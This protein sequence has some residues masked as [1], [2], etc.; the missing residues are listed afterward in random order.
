M[1]KTLAAA[2][3]AAT[4]SAAV[5]AQ[6]PD[7]TPQR[8]DITLSN[9]SFDPGHVVLEHG[10][11]YVLHIVNQAGGGHDFTAK[12]FFAAARIAPEDRDRVRD[13][14][15]E[16]HGHESA[17]LH[18]VAPAPGYYDLHCG[19]LMH[20]ALGMKGAIEVR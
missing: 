2:L 17:D 4:L 10:A 12:Q 1:R 3:L 19:H 18:L 5:P 14:T 11:A 16:L 6:Q 13:G 7:T 8:I 9:F 20:A 15:I